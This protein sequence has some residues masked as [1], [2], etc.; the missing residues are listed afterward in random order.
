VYVGVG[1][2]GAVCIGECLECVCTCM[3]VWV[4]VVPCASVCV[5]CVCACMCMWV[6]VS[7]VRIGVYLDVHPRE[8]VPSAHS[9]LTTNKARRSCTP[10]SIVTTSI[11]TDPFILTSS[12]PNCPLYPNYLHPNCPFYPN[13]CYP[14]YYTALRPST[15]PICAA[16]VHYS[17]RV[18]D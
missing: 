18:R 5:V 11:L 14:T 9:I 16:R 12:I 15:P 3:W 6:W 17:R 2:G 4:W 8:S 10:P 1:V 13:Y 7:R